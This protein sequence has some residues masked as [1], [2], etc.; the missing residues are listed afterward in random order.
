MPAI[1]EVYRPDLD[2]WGI[3]KKILPGKVLELVSYEKAGHTSFIN[4]VCSQGDE[5]SYLRRYCFDHES[6]DR[7]QVPYNPIEDEILPNKPFYYPIRMGVDQRTH[8]FVF[9]HEAVFV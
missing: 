4:L 5:L 1:V 2:K 9:R 3:W 7:I 6:L 8:F